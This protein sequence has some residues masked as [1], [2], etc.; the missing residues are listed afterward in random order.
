[1]NEITEKNIAQVFPRELNLW[2]MAIGA[3]LAD[4]DFRDKLLEAVNPGDIGAGEVS[5]LLKAIKD[6]NAKLVWHELRVVFRVKET[7][8][9]A[10]DAILEQLRGLSI[11][12]GLREANDT[13]LLNLFNADL[14]GAKEAMIRVR[15]YQ[16]KLGL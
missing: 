1:M 15:E 5:P 7:H 12:R 8:P 14:A 9:K 2:C 4:D 11:G 16:E 13:V 10:I 3:A 6:R